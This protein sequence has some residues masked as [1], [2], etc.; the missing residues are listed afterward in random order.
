VG[1]IRGRWASLAAHEG[2][3]DAQNRDASPLFSGA[4]EALGA[5]LFERTLEGL[6]ETDVA[7]AVAPLA[8]RIEALT[9]ELEDAANAAAGVPSG[10]VCVAV[11][12]VVAEHFLIPRLPDLMKRFPDIAFDIH[13]DI[14]RRSLS[15]REA[16]IA[17]R[18]YPEG[19]PPAEPS[20]LAV[21]VGKL[22]AAAYAS[23]EYIERFGRPAY[24]ARSLAGHVMIRTE[25]SPGDGWNATLDEPAEYAL[26]VYPFASATVAAVFGIGIAILPCSPANNVSSASV[27][28]DASMALESS[29]RWRD[30]GPLRCTPRPPMK[31]STLTRSRCIAPTD[32]SPRRS[33][34]YSTASVTRGSTH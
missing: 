19:T 13:A 30:V 8:E 24:P 29:P 6:I 34:S 17:I 28:D 11:S 5:R 22:A 26:S 2:L 9:H 27:G 16:D 1:S 20:A 31:R 14:S 4:E 10:P 25:W 23:H 33:K 18:Q 21:K 15:K 12:P 32:D 3:L 7:V